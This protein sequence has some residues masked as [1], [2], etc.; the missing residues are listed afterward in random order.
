[1]RSCIVCKQNKTEKI[2]VVLNQLTNI[3]DKYDKTQNERNNFCF[4]VNNSFIETKNTCHDLERNPVRS[5]SKRLK[6]KAKFFSTH[7]SRN[8]N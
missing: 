3:R 2:Y 8:T 1:M 6:L 7:G 4:F 5:K